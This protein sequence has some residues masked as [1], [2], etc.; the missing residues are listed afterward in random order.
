MICI[1]AQIEKLKQKAAERRKTRRGG[2][3]QSKTA[4]GVNRTI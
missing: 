3:E 4:A 1:L 2:T